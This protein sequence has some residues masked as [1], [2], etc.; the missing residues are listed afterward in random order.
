MIRIFSRK[1]SG[2]VDN[3][4]MARFSL[5]AKH[6][7]DAEGPYAVLQRMNKTRTLYIRQALSQFNPN[8]TLALPLK[9]MNIL[10]I[11][12]GG[13]FLSQSLTRLGANVVGADSNLDH[14]NIA[15]AHDGAE[16]IEFIHTTAEELAEKGLQ[17]DSVCGLEIVEH[18]NDPAAFIQTCA[19]L[20]KVDL[21][22][23][24]AKRTLVSLYH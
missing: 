22:V 12:C 13:G 16:K 7:W 24:I 1:L 6:W 5:V 21:L 8:A 23:T 18:V 4:E 20:V 15:K 3:A 11:G 19:S 9:G 14:I 10:D 17:F 2:S